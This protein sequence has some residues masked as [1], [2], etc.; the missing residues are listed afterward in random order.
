MHS[1]QRNL[2]L[3]FRSQGNDDL[4]FI[5][6]E[7]RPSPGRRSQHPRLNVSALAWVR[8]TGTWQETSTALV[9]Q[10]T[11]HRARVGLKVRCTAQP[12]KQQQGQKEMEPQVARE[13]W[14]ADHGSRPTVTLAPSPSRTRGSRTQTTK[15]CSSFLYGGSFWHH[16]KLHTEASNPLLWYTPLN[17]ALCFIRGNTFHK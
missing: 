2:H 1:S 11:Q 14:F 15:A 13:P 5:I 16:N 17:K 4:G 6:P 7:H 12:A 3:L 10:G 9:E 8:S